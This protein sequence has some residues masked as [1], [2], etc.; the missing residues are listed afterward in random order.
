MGKNCSFDFFDL[1]IR[2]GYSLLSYAM[3]ASDAK[4][5]TSFQ[6]AI[7]ESIKSCKSTGRPGI[8]ETGVLQEIPK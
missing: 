5:F 2:E 1:Q 3:M 4:K 6:R 7:Q 8:D